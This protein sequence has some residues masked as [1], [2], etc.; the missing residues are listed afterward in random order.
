M[1][2]PDLLANELKVLT[3]QQKTILSNLNAITGAINQIKRLQRLT[4]E[5]PE[6]DK[7]VAGSGNV[8]IL[9]NGVEKHRQEELGG[10]GRGC[11][12]KGP[13]L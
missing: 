12:E 2:F 4:S 8:V 6:A 5:L 3:E 10:V 13:L 9:P 7:T 1:T 11:T